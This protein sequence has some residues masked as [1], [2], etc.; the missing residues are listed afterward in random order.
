MAF[1]KNGVGKYFVVL[2]WYTEKGRHPSEPIALLPHLV[3]APPLLTKS[4]D[5]L[6]IDCVLNGALMIPHGKEHWALMSA[7]EHAAYNAL[8]ASTA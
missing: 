5:V 7:R 1:L 3:L 2:R 6:P 4:Y 8:N